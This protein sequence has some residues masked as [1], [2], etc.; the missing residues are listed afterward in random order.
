[1]E[2]TVTHEGG[3]R[4]NMQKLCLVIP[5]FNDWESFEIL[6]EEIDKVAAQLS[7]QVAILAIDDG[8]TV[9]PPENL[10]H[11]EQLRHIVNI[12]LV[13]LT[14]NLGHQR[15]IAV[16]LC[17]AV[18][19]NDCDAML[20]MDGD[21]EDSPGAIQ[22]MLTEVDRKPDF[23]VVARRGK[24]KESLSFKFFYVLYKIL[25]R[26][27][28]G[29]QIAFGNFCL[30]SRGYARRLVSLPEL[31]NNLPAA[32]LRSR[33]PIIE[34]AV[35]RAERYAGKSKMSLTALV[36]HGLSGISVYAETIFLRFLMLTFS[37]FVLSG[38]LIAL[39]LTLRVFFPKYATPGWATTVTFGISIILVQALSFTLSVILMLLHNRVQRLFIPRVDYLCYVESRQVCLCCKGIEV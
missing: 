20:V 17:V 34:V 6:I 8:S 23:C 19:D 15:A 9:P 32:I 29:R 24:R 7:V 14:T 26:L 5:V 39:V 35:D 2:S 4:S 30:I 21:G 38:S 10:F 3:G 36:V 33:L 11:P 13:H 18:E 12:D 25:F 37:L 22:Q 16:G 28:T 1:V 27:L 31:W